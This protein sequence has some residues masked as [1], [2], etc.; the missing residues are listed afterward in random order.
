MEGARQD[1]IAVGMGY[2]WKLPAVFV[3]YLAIAVIFTAPVSLSPHRLAVNDGDPLHISWILAWDV[4]QLIRDPLH[5]FDSNSFHPYEGSL[6]FSE[7]L[8]VPALL[9]APFFYATGNAL[10]AQNLTVV[11]TLALSALAMFVLVLAIFGRE[12]AALFAGM[13]Y[14]FHTYNSHEV[15]RLQ[16]LS[17]QFWP[18]ALLYLHRLFTLGGRKNAL[19]FAAFFLLQGLSCTYYLIYFA[20]VL[21]IWIPAYA[22]ATRGGFRRALTLVLPLT[23]V[24][25]VLALF[26]LPYQKMLE[27]YGY[28]RELVE[29]LDALEY[30]RPPEE[31]LL[32]RLITYDFEPS[33]VPQFVGFLSLALAVSGLVRAPR[34]LF[35]WLTVATAAVGFVLSLG[36]TIRVGERVLGPGFYGLLYR[37]FSFFQVLRNPERLSLL[38]HFGLAI[39]AGWGAAALASRFSARTASALRVSLLVLLPLEHFR[40]GQP[41]A[42]LPTGEETPDVYRWLST[43]PHDGAVVELPLYRRTELRRHA[44]YMYYSTY[45]WKPIVFGRTS[46]YPPLPGYLAWEL[47]DFPDGDSLA[48]LRRVGVSRIVVHP[49]LWPPADR[50]RKLALLDDF[51]EDLVPE[52]RF[53]FLEGPLFARYGFGGERVFRLGTGK[54]VSKETLCSPV[55]EIEPHRFDLEGEGVTPIGWAVDRNRETKWKSEGQLPGMKIEIDFRREET[56]SAVRFALGHPYDEFP[57]DVTLKVSSAEGA[58]FERIVHRED[59]A[60]KLELVDAL[61]ENPGEAAITLRFDPVKVLRLRVWLREGKGFDY[62]LPDWSLPEIFLYRSCRAAD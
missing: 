45:H 57:R 13:V 52:G 55:D 36:P 40:G 9:S 20:L 29:G 26:A 18:L 59:L 31:N 23:L 34:R 39:L 51:T 11:L 38:V 37:N 62:S 15:A 30:L 24:G 41:F 50:G 54:P 35:L 6:A 33:A 14:V 42:P 21:T 61:I 7:H 48:L 43:T 58:P 5:L 53:P 28:Q 1:N 27:R 17:V 44:L 3:F 60:T 4:H 46:F 49:Q 32:S 25:I 10:L 56:L 19:L 12:D 8:I 2:R 16:L 47:R 22:L